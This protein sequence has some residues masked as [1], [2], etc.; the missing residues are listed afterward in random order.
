MYNLTFSPSLSSSPLSFTQQTPAIVSS[1]PADL[2]LQQKLRFV[3][4]TS[5][6]RWA[7]IIFWHKMFDEPSN[8]SYLVWV[9]GHFCGNKNNKSQENY[10]TNSIECELM[11]DGGDDLEL[12]YATS[13]YSEDGS[14]R[15]E[16][17][18]ESLVWLTGLDELRFSNYERAKEAGFH[19]VHTLVSI[20][21]NNGI[22]ELGSSDSII[23][24]RNFINRVQSIF[25]S[26][27]TPEHTNQTGS[28]PKPAES[29]HSEIGNRQSGSERKRRRKLETMDVAVAAEE[30]H[31]PPVLSHVEAERQR[32]E[33][34]NHRFYALRAIVPKVSRM[35]KASLLSDAVSYIE[36][37]K[38]KIDDLETEIKKLKT[39]MTET[40]KLDNNS[41]NTS[42]FSVEY[43]I[44]QKPSE[45]NRV[46][47]LEVQ[48]KVVG[49]EAI[50]RV[51]T[52]NVNHPT[53][54]LM[55]A[56]ME[57]DCRVQH[58]NASRLSQ[59]V[60]QDVVVLVPEG[61]RSEDGLRT[62]LSRNLR[63]LSSV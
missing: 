32:R 14:P 30:K 41:S 15:K 4:E 12:F 16:I 10:T 47:D 6:D 63:S 35:D 40:D 50:I 23:Q 48:V 19:G 51:Q 36:S 39:K 29:D 58:A 44:N 2:A 17:F 56:L 24:N 28:D 8:R 27:K 13:F 21:I 57:M 22:I 61:L 42:P 62:T 46:S 25:G 26:G 7:Y 43:Q 55:S 18:D 34:L 20:P 54:A 11:M 49:Y 31:H 33:K 60:V 59:V 53:S 52:E 37:L 9:D 5:P 3:V 45:S 1:S 38:S